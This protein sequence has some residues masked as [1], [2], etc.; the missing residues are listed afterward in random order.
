MKFL[1]KHRNKIIIILIA[2]VLLVVSFFMGGNGK[3]NE[4]V[5]NR[6]NTASKVAESV[7]K[8]PT[9]TEKIADN[10]ITTN[11]AEPTQTESKPEKTDEPKAHL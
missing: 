3:V 5:V 9:Q 10:I 11:S 6:E 8:A 1:S 4:N 2:I 7:D